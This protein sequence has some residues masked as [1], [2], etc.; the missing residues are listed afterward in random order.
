MFL[1]AQNCHA[2]SSYQD[3]FE[4]PTLNS[5][6]QTTQTAGTVTFPSSSQVHGGTQSVRVDSTFNTGDK[7][8]SL[9]HE[10]P[11]PVFGEASVWFYDTGADV[12]SSNYLWLQMRNTLL[13]ELAI[14]AAADYDLGPTTGGTYYFQPFGTN[15]ATSTAIDRTQAWHQYAIKALPDSFSISIDGTNVYSAAGGVPF[16][17]IEFGMSGPTW[18]PAW[19]GYFDD[20][21]FTAVPEPSAATFV[22][23]GLGVLFAAGRRA[24]SK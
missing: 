4:G 23:L 20:F 11:Q 5:F 18:R 17:Y 1:V 6:W 15:T 22:T 10:F 21:R 12:S 13:G 16:D 7:L 2:Q 8:I 9:R 19:T 24:R 14:V 3:D